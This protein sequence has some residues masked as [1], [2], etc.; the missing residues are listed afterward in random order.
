MRRLGTATAVLAVT[1]ALLLSGCDTA[2]AADSGA[3]PEAVEQ[4]A[5]DVAAALPTAELLVL[6][7]GGVFWKASRA[8]QDALARHLTP[9]D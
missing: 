8:A 6:P 9:E 3:V 2:P 1:G 4:V 5:V 7:Q